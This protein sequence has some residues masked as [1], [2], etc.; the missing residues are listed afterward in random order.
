MLLYYCSVNYLDIR[1]YCVCCHGQWIYL[2]VGGIVIVMKN[3]RFHVSRGIW[4]EGEVVKGMVWVLS[5]L[6][7][8]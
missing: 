7:E 6:P 2:I 1:L 4:L 5:L 8:D 3:C